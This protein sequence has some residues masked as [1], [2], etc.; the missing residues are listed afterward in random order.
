MNFITFENDKELKNFLKGMPREKLEN[1]EYGILKNFNKNRVLFTAEHAYTKR[2]KTPQYGKRSYVKI[3]DTNTD[4]LA[5]IMAE[6]LKSAFLISRLSRV[7]ADVSRPISTLG[8]DERILIEVFNSKVEN[9]KYFTIHRNKDYAPFWKKYH[10]M[11]E[12]LKP[13]AIICVHGMCERGH[14]SDI[15][16]GLGENYKIIGG[17][18]NALEFKNLYIKRVKEAF[19]RLGIEDKLKINIS[20]WLFTGEK[21]YV[22][23]KHAIQYNKNSEKKRFGIHVEFNARGRISKGSF[24]RKDY[25]IATQVLADTVLEWLED[26]GNEKNI[27]KDKIT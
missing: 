16:L 12:K 10:S 1:L 15:L 18:K 9:K 19:S 11:I 27:L 17:K 13:S 26:Y 14:P 21:N 2:V 23:F 22:L 5:I 6:R 20:K 3:G 24:I 4:I 25:Q 7:E 8:S